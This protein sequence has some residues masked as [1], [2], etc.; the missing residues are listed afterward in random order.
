[1]SGEPVAY[2]D[3]HGT[4]DEAKWRSIVRRVLE[5]HKIVDGVVT[6][7]LVS[8]I[9]AAAPAPTVSGEEPIYRFL[10]VGEIVETGDENPTD[11]CASWEPVMRVA[12]GYP[13][14]RIYKTIRRR[15]FPA[16]TRAEV[17]EEAI[18]AQPA[19]HSNPTESPY[20]RG[21]FNAVQDYADA[22][23]ALAGEKP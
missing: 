19:T 2:A 4:L 13:V 6:A 3:L 14:A 10:C 15:V 16:P 22:I 11:D 20:D 17:L 12:V 5:H 9:L 8:A 1:M 7:D 18:R 21:Y 23:R